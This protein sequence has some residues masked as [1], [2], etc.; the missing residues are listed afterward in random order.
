MMFT[1]KKNKTQDKQKVEKVETSQG[2]E[3]SKIQ[4]KEKNFSPKSFHLP[5]TDLK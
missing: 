3:T 5:P 1:S 4:E 2:S